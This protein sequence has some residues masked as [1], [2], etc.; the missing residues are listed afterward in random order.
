MAAGPQIALHLI[1]E[2][3]PPMPTFLAAA[4]GSDPK[5]LG[6]QIDAAFGEHPRNVHA[7]SVGERSGPDIP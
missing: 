5:A 1:E 6:S 4:L 3:T 7:S 2:P